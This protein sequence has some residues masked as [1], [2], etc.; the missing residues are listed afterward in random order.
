MNIK[1][2]SDIAD[3][4]QKD[5]EE[6]SILSILN[7]LS[8]LTPPMDTEALGIGTDNR[9]NWGKNADILIDTLWNYANGDTELPKIDVENILK[10][11]LEYTDFVT[12]SIAWV[13]ALVKLENR[14]L[15]P[16]NLPPSEYSNEIPQ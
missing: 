2:I 11:L 4:L 12:D 8:W 16:D 5:Q 6:E 14:L 10:K 13:Q 15:Q 1:K 9:P 7:Q 3:L